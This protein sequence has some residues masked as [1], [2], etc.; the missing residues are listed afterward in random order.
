LP[1]A[2]GLGIQNECNTFW[3]PVATL[4]TK[5]I[6]QT[7]CCLGGLGGFKHRLAQ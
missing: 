5:R 3:M 4:I 7:D 6:K 1:V 2:S